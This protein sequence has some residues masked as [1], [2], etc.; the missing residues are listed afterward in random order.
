MLLHDNE[1]ASTLK[2]VNKKVTIS[3]ESDEGDVEEDEGSCGYIGA[4]RD[5]W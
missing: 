3:Y 1:D 4:W 5:S 2:N